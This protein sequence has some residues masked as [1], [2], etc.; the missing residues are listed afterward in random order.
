MLQGEP[1]YDGYMIEIATLL[2]C[3]A[4]VLLVSGLV[5]AIRASISLAYLLTQAAILGSGFLA[6]GY[7]FYRY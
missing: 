4:I 2:S 6:Y 5:F 7:L 3:V 1:G